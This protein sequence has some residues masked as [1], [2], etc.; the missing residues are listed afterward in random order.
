MAV[1][2]VVKAAVDRVAP[3]PARAQPQNQRHSPSVVSVPGQAKRLVHNAPVEQGPSVA[4]A[5][6]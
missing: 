2:A 5:K 3:I 1:G 6:V 4:V